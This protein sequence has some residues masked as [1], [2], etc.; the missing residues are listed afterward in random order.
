MGGRDEHPAV[1]LYESL[2]FRRLS[3]REVAPGVWSAQF[4][5]WHCHLKTSFDADV[6]GYEAAPPG[7]PDA[8]FDLL[9]ARCGLGSAARVLELGPV[10]G[11]AT[12]PLLDRGATV[13]AVEPG[14]AMAARLRERVE[15]RNCTVVEAEF[16][17][18]D[19]RGPFDLAVAATSF[20]WVDP[21]LGLDKLA[22]LVR[23]GGLLAL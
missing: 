6:A 14:V 15:G 3:R 12:V 22:N 20:H 7:Y 10:T 17:Q 18:A 23:P 2:F 11:Q 21:A 4:E 8:L 5:H 13:V 19:V 9:S 1:A 16:E